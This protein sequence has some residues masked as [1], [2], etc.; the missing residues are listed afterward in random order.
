ME[1]LVYDDADNRIPIKIGGETYHLTTSR[2]VTPKQARGLMGLY[3]A[4]DQ[5]IKEND[6][7]KITDVGVKILSK[8][9]D[10]P[11]EVLEGLKLEFIGRLIRAHMG[12][13]ADSD[14]GKDQPAGA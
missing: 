6:F 13:K 7:D 8:V 3:Q 2:E 1:P 11:A 14:G 10:I 5:A 12:T 4:N 9:T